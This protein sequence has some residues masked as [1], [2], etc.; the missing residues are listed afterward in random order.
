MFVLPY[1]E[2]GP[3]SW[4]AFIP[5]AMC[6][7]WS[8]GDRTTLVG[9]WYPAVLWMLP[10]LDRTTPG[11]L[12]DD[13]GMVMIGGLAIA[14]VVFLRVR[15]ARRISLWL[16]ASPAPLA[17]TRPLVVL[18]ER[19]GPHL[20]RAAWSLGASAL[21]FAA[22]AWLAP[23]LWHAEPLAPVTKHVAHAFG[24]PC[25]PT[26]DEADA[27]K[28]RVKEYFDLGRGHDAAAADDP[29]HR[30][31][32]DCQRCEGIGEGVQIAST[33]EPVYS[34]PVL[35]EPYAMPP[36]TTP[37][38]T[39]DE[40]TEPGG[41]VGF[42]AGTPSYA[43][44]P[45]ASPGPAAPAPV[46]APAPMPAPVAAPGPAPVAAPGPA[47]V[48]VAA[49]P[50]AHV[51]AP[52][53][54]APAPYQPHV[55]PAVPAP[56]PPIA[57][58]HTIDPPRPPPANGPSLLR[59]AALALG[60]IFAAQLVLLALRPLRRM[61]TLRHFRRPYWAETVDQRVSNAW[62]LALVGLRDAGWRPRTDEPPQ[63]LA[64]RVDVDGLDRC[65]TILERA[66]HGVGLDAGDLATMTTSADAAY[67][68][69]RGRLGP[70]ARVVT[71]LRW[72]LA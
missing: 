58:A 7:Y 12:P 67:R 6:A 28:A 45:V 32:I 68:S 23:A 3:H 20:S 72:P 31:G 8:L 11:A 51:A 15:E 9:F 17:A 19:T 16:A 57:P 48:A 47:P 5:A 13:S 22:A 33:S 64:R 43:P 70:V 2:M 39:I 53:P 69:A 34:H 36:A 4:H 55:A 62:Q 26:H 29:P 61:V 56:P 30:P 41:A 71:W 44:A 59:Y 37:A 35:A 24:L 14:F 52:A 10:I 27:P 66:R 21:A 42:R 1:D 63:D 50:P 60:A 25:C 54:I 49:P 38:T 65:A 40:W 46:A 18:R